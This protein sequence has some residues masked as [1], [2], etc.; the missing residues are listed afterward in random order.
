MTPLALFLLYIMSRNYKTWKLLV[1]II[2]PYPGSILN[3]RK[4]FVDVNDTHLKCSDIN[5]DVPQGSVISLFCVSLIHPCLYHVKQCLGLQLNCKNMI[6]LCSF[7]P[8]IQPRLHPVKQCQSSKLNCKKS[9][10]AYFNENLIS[11]HMCSMQRLIFN[12]KATMVVQWYL[13][14]IEE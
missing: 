1:Y 6:C 4:Q 8:M 11:L 9:L 12:A 3:D 13:Y 5:Y 7:M 10:S 14:I 2:K